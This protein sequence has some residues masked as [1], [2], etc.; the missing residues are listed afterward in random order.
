[1]TPVLAWVVFPLVLTTV[2]VGIGLLVERLS[3]SRLPTSLLLP[4]GC[5]AALAVL[6]TT[7][8]LAAWPLDVV[9]ITMATIAGFGWRDRSV[10]L[11]DRVLGDRWAAAAVPIVYLAYLLP[12]VATGSATF[13]GWIKLDDGATWLA[14]GQ[15]I[16]EAGRTLEGMAPSTSEALISGLWDTPQWSGGYP[17]T[18]FAPLGLGALLPG[19]DPTSL[20]Q[21]YLAFLAAVLASALLAILRRLLVALPRLRAAGA[22]MA[23]LAALLYGYAM[24]GGVKEVALAP[25]IPAAA[26][27][28]LLATTACSGWRVVRQ[29]VPLAVLLAGAVAIGGLPSGVWF[30]VPVVWWAGAAL[31]SGGIRRAASAVAALAAVTG[32]VLA[33][34]LLRI[35]VGALVYLTGFAA[36]SDD[37]G[38][39]WAHLGREQVVGVW[40]TGDFRSHPAR[41]DITW[42]LIALVVALAA[43]GFVWA[44]RRRFGEVVLY[45]AAT[46]P[47]ALILAGGG[48]WAAGKSLAIASPA[49]LTA[50]A[51]GVGLLWQQRRRTEA[52]VAA[53]AVAAGVLTG[54]ALTYREAWLAP[55]QELLELTDIGAGPKEW[56]PALIVDY[57]PYGARVLLAPLDAQGAGE[58]RRDVI[59]LLDG[60]GLG[61]AAYADIDDFQTAGLSPFNSLVLRRSVVGSRPPSDFRLVRDGTDYQVWQRD[62]GLPQPARRLPLGSHDDPAEIVECSEVRALGRAA[63]AMG[64][65]TVLI[66]AQRGEM[67]SVDLAGGD[68]PDGWLSA[69][70]PGS[71]LPQA[72]GTARYRLQV[73]EDGVY[74]MM[75]R[76]GFRGQV[77]VRIDGEEVFRDRHRLV[78][79]GNGVM[80]PEIE[81]AAGEHTVELEYSEPWWAP[82]VGKQD[83]PD[84]G[85]PLA[86][87]MGPLAF[88][89]T[90]DQTR[91]LRVAPDE[92]GSLC[93]RQLDWVEAVPVPASGG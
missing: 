9:A 45:A 2:A 13:A 39:L 85:E 37:I 47:L 60:Q 74:P 41:T 69:G 11:R 51:A 88:G 91:L 92:T 34:E 21:P 23:A 3:G 82:G 14:L 26:T 44:V 89:P 93:G 22:V 27:V 6:L 56:A 61:K 31:R 87:T 35:D 59:P 55:R 28:V 19:A 66:A 67:M 10:P 43:V 78:W 30:A 73:T 24:W 20:L 76:G 4:L 42:I 40:P 12:V 29:T 54:T 63:A 83:G 79:A 46:V 33:V 84:G 71:V 86:W 57:S 16:A 25:L 1:M 72:P 70:A 65:G 58:L 18:G 68:L 7:T 75:L 80:G 15:R 77:V 52:A 62:P 64:P 8:T 50:A 36:G 49:L 90:A 81:L 5:A 38:T 17:A 32:A 53:G 48:A